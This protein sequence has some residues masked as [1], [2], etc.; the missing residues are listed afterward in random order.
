MRTKQ[1]MY[2]DEEDGEEETLLLQGVG[3]AR[4]EAG[5]RLG[6]ERHIKAGRQVARGS[7]QQ[8]KEGE[9]RRRVSFHAHERFHQWPLAP[10][11][12]VA[13]MGS[14]GAVSAVL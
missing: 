8:G 4:R 14:T 10:L 13:P 5:G 12:V 2:D 7:Q 9:R 6:G 3:K 1:S 11:V